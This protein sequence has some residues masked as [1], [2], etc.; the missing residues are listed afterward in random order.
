MS[1]RRQAFKGTACVALGEGVGY[2]ASFVRN[3]IL[4]RVL[5]KADFGM[6][7]V[8]GMVMSLLELTAKLSIGRFLVRDKEGD[9]PEF[10][11]TGHTLQAMAAAVSAG[12]IVSASP[13]LARWFG[14][15]EH[16]WALMVLAGVVLLRGLQHLD[17]QRY[18]RH[19]RFGPSASVEAIPQVAMTLAA[20]PV[21]WWLG[22]YRA[23]L[24]LLI[25]KA[26]LS[27]LL[28]H[29]LAER[30]YR[31]VWHGAYARRML[32]FGWPLVLTGFLMFGIM[33][34][35]QFLVATFY[36]LSDLAPYA[37]AV[38]LVMAPQFVFGKVFN[39]VALPLVARE[40]DDPVA[41]ARR[42]GQVMAGMLLYAAVSTTALMVGAEA[43]MRLVYGPKY[44][45]AGLVMSW[46]AAVAG[47]RALRMG[48]AVANI[49]QGDSQSQLLANLGRAVSLGPAFWLAWQGKPLWMVAA[50]GLVGEGLATAVCVWRL[51]RLHR[52]PIPLTL[53][54]ALM[55]VMVAAASGMLG[56]WVADLPAWAGVLATAASSLVAGMLVVLSIPVLRREAV[57]LWQGLRS[58]GALTALRRWMDGQPVRAPEACQGPS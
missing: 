22:D 3:M 17:T 30:P 24:V 12:L 39:S 2:G 38:S 29:L 25:G 58:A 10:V 27:L 16:A 11:A 37:A 34:G 36:S 50:C 51:W 56:Y 8:F 13:W 54:P 5:S 18:E 20:W 43:L 31:W 7:A 46:L 26:V 40:Q 55:M 33:Q 1:V 14:V 57:V 48:V 41:F 19:L 21:A 35:D 49:A 44:V 52:I 4:A 15:P 32:E 53:R 45:G 9:D 28:S 6:A 42:Y 47:F 23:V